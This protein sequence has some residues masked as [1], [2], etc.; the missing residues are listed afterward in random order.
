MGGE[1]PRRLLDCHVHHIT[2]GFSV[3]ENLKRLRVVTPPTAIFTRH[4]GAREKI[5][6]EFDHALSFACFATAAFS[7]KGKSAAG[8]AAYPRNR[9]LRVKIANFVKDFD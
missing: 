8:I 7:I 4:V 5:H 1:K 9:Q 2:D 3:V 6:L